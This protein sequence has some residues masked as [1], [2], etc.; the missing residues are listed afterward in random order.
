MAVAV[1]WLNAYRD[2]SLAE[3][4]EL[5]D[6]AASLECA[7]SGRKIIVGKPAMAAYWRQRFAESPVL[8]VE[9][10]NREGDAAV[11]LYRVAG[12]VVQV[13][14]DI[15]S[16]AKINRVRC[17]PVREIRIPLDLGD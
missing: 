7:C 11:L 3:M 4:M 12:G 1:A 6:E 8:G 10:L 9:D 17:G 2:A 15:N 5:H 14:I 13:L 16:A